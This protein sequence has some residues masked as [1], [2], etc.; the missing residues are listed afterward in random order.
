M[1]VCVF[2]CA[3]VCVC[4]CV[5]VCAECVRCFA[6]FDLNS[7]QCSEEIG[8]ADADDC[9]QNI[10]YGYQAADG[11]CQSCGHLVWSL[12]SPWSPCNVLCGE[13]VRQRSRACFGIG[14]SECR[15]IKDKLQTEPCSGTCCDDKGWGLW[16]PWSTCSVTCGEGGV[17]KRKRVCPSPPEC[18]SACSGPSEETETCPTHTCPVHG[19]WSGWSDWSQ[20]SGKCIDDQRGDVIAPTKQRHRSCSNPT[21]SKDT[22]PN[23]NDCPGDGVD[24]QV[25]S[26]LPNCPVDGSWGAWSAP[27]KC[28]VSCGEGLQLSTRTCNQPAPKYGGRFCDGPS[29]RSSVCQS[30]CPVDGFWTG[31]SSWGECSA[32]CIPQGPAPIRRRHR[33]CSNPAPSSSPPGRHCQGD[34]SQTENCNHL[35]HCPV[36]GGW[37]SWSSFSS[38]P[39]TC[40][41]GLQV[42]VRRCDRPAPKHGG[43]PC[44]GKARQTTVCKT[45]VHCPVDGVWSEWS[46]WSKCRYPFSERDI[47]CKQVGGTQSRERE[48]LH[49]AHNGTICDD[50]GLTDRRVCYDVNGCLMGGNWDGWEPWAFCNPPCGRNSKRSRRRRCSIDYSHYRAAI[51]RQKEK[52]SFAGFPIPDCRDPPDGIK[53]EKQPCINVP[54]C[55]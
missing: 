38:C 12:W 31:W 51:G 34:D 45:N 36:D 24:I 27:G 15:N 9:C 11:V 40:G 26:E 46:A 32:S 48:C 14:H 5:Y 19:G 33:S 8:E 39:V 53:S 55:P 52:A 1:H 3:F 41:V 6:H 37:G 2:V 10:K 18:L 35:P 21:P 28:S 4:V 30:T 29:T 44:T 47:N 13:G 54:A 17:R 50:V 20:C 25:C 42:S 22:E 16:L 23:G 7:T 43:R 49:R